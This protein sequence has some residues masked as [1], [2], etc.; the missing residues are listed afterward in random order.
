MQVRISGETI[1]ASLDGTDWED[2]SLTELSEAAVAIRDA[3]GTLTLRADEA[4]VASGLGRDVLGAIRESGASY[5]VIL[6]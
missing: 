3:G 5:T 2:V 4:V 6:A 1:E